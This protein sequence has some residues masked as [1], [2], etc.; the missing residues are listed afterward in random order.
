MELSHRAVGEIKRALCDALDDPVVTDA[1]AAIDAG[2]LAPVWKWIAVAD[3]PE[4]RAAFQQTLAVR[5]LSPEARGLADRAFYGTVVRLHRASEGAPYTGLKL[6]GTDPGEAIRSAD[7]ALES[8][9]LDA[10]RALILRNVE[11]GLEERFEAARCARDH[12]EHDAAAGRH[13]VHAYVEFVHF[14]QRLHEVARSEA[15]RASDRHAH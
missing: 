14:A 2:D 5:S 9:S 6:A 10:L 3:E 13:S 15:A 11:R 4:V 8:G 7:A 12:A 1:R